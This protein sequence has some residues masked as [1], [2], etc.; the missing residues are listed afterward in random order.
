[1][2]RPIERIAD[3]LDR[4]AT[5]MENQAAAAAS[6]IAQLPPEA[7]SKEESAKFLGIDVKSLDHLIRIKKISYVQH[8]SQR[9]RVIPVKSLRD[10]L[11]VFFTRAV[12]NGSKKN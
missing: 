11:N 9:G 1:M 6:V 4:I 8:G 12:S 2:G 5:A 3:A 7:L 10:F